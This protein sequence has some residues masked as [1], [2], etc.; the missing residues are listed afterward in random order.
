MK[1]DVSAFL[2]SVQMQ[3]LWIRDYIESGRLEQA[4]EC[5]FSLHLRA[6][7][8]LPRPR[9]DGSTPPAPDTDLEIPIALL[10]SEKSQAF[11]R[12]MRQA[13]ECARAVNLERG[14][15]HEGSLA[16]ILENLA[17]SVEAEVFGPKGLRG[18]E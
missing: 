18:L 17:D 12:A 2:H 3:A 1:T 14:L 10:N 8:A 16:E 7:Q 11:A 6:A 5:A 13:A 4:K 9:K 15:P